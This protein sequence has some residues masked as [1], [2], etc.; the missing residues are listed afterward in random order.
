MSSLPANVS[1]FMSRLQGVSSSHYKIHPQSGDTGTSGKIIRFELPSNSY[2]NLR[3]LRLFFGVTL[4]GAGASIPNDV[5]SF[6]DRVSVYA[7]GVLVSN[8]FQ[9]YNVLRHAKAG[10]EGQK[11][12]SLLSHP[13]IV[14]SKSYHDGTVFGNT[15]PEKYDDLDDQFCIDNWEG[16]LGSIEPSIIDLGT[17]PQIMIEIQLGDDTVCPISEGRVLPDGTG[18][19]ADNFD[20]VGAGNPTTTAL[21]VSRLIRLRGIN[22]GLLTVLLHTLINLPPLLRQAIKRQAD[23]FLPL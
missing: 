17:M 1:F 13:N 11:C 23:M 14:R 3:N 19:L 16:I 5:S 15:D 20:K 2:V 9:G 7:G 12:N 10:L 21:P 6:I 18:A 4:A 22:Y 8:N